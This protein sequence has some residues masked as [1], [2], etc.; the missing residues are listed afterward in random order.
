IKSKSLYFLQG[1]PSVGPSI[2]NTLLEY[3]G[4]PENVVLASEEEL[5]EI[6]GLGAKKARRIRKFLSQKLR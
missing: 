2:S 4:S 6:E 1:L 5:M 3:F